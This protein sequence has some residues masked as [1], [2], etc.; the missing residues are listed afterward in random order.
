M[1]K[2]R[3][4]STASAWLNPASEKLLTKFMELEEKLPGI[5]AQQLD[6]EQQKF[7]ETCK[8]Y[9]KEAENL[10]ECRTKF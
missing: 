9:L 5:E 10:L 6:P 2:Y 3:L 1:T 8:T 4:A 7:V